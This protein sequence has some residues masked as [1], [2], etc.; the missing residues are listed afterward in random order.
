MGL[1]S[2]VSVRL[3]SVCW[4]SGFRFIGCSD[5]GL[6][7]KPNWCVQTSVYFTRPEASKPAFLNLK[8]TL[9]SQALFRKQ[10]CPQHDHRVEGELDP[11]VQATREPESPGRKPSLNLRS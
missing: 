5:F 11:E 1:R 8:L 2:E 10:V 3:A 9:S 7:P 6:N 4:G